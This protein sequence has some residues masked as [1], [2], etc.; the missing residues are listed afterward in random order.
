MEA[1]HL[2]GNYPF[3]KLSL[4]K[5]IRPYMPPRAPCEPPLKATRRTNSTIAI[6]AIMP[7]G[8]SNGARVVKIG[9]ML[10]TKLPNATVEKPEVTREPES[11]AITNPFVQSCFH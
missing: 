7:T 4:G 8:R 2:Q 11:V 5:A 9:E 10:F 6:I 1:S 3:P